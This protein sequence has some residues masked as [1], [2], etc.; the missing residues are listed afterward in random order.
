MNNMEIAHDLAMLYLSSLEV[1]DYTPAEL[2]A[3]YTRV[4][5]EIIA[6]LSM[7]KAQRIG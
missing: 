2:T 6:S 5:A 3:E 1:S 7:N 4:K